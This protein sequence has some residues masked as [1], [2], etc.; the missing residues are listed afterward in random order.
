M[1]KLTPEQAEK[2]KELSSAYTLDEKVLPRY[3]IEKI[4]IRNDGQ[5]AIS[6]RKGYCTSEMHFHHHTEDFELKDY[7]EELGL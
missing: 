6:F 1:T 7:R 2:V 3:P 5:I 4:S